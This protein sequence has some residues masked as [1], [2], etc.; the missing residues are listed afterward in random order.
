MPIYMDVHIV[1]GV[2]A[3]EV[4][5]AH[6]LDLEHQHEF[7]C[8]CMTY[9]LDETKESIFCLIDAPNK[10][11]VISMHN[12]S[13]GL[14]PNRIIEVQSNLV[15]SFLG[16][17]YDPADATITE[18]GLKVFSEPSFRIVMVIKSID[19]I[20]LKHQLG[21]TKMAE[22]LSRQTLQIRAH[23]QQFGGREVEH[24]GSDFI[25]SFNSASRALNCALAIT[26]VVQEAGGK[27]TGFKIGIHAG[28]PIEKS[29]QLF[30][31]ALKVAANICSVAGDFQVA[32][33]GV[34]KELVA[35]D[36]I[37][38]KK[39][40]VFSLSAA[41]ESLL[42]C[43]YEQLEANWREPEFNLENYSQAMAMSQSQLYRKTIS[44]SGLS[45]NVLLKDF[46]LEKA[47]EM[48]QKKHYSIAQ[49]TFECGFSSPSYFTKCFK[50]KYGLLPNTYL[51]L[52]N[53]S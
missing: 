2:K 51:E 21:V 37:V 31:D 26:E 24:P 4:A 48:M 29:E 25:A 10:E 22:L 30:G 49:V 23:L 35:K 39:N 11:A 16:R 43:L 28:E 42:N 20:L 19:R 5:Q 14:I 40:A 44:L 7:G 34:I 52:V 18:D 32:I 3:L 27:E 9:W 53:A 15:E 41:D 46:R 45:P 50:N 33:T 36:I 12:K 38:N 1:P 13:H 17:I 6:Y 8:K 47:K